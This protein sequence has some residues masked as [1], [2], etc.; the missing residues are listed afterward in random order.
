MLRSWFYVVLASAALA[1]VGVAQEPRPPAYAIASRIPGPDGGWD[2]ASVDPTAQRLYV[3]RTDGVM[4]VD[5]AS[6]VVTPHLVASAHGHAALAIPGTREVISTNGEANTAVIFDGQSGHIRATIPT[7]TKPDAVVFDPATATL[8]IMNPGSGDI[9]VV[10]PASAAVLATVPVGGSLELGAA[11]GQ[12]Q[13]FVNVEDRNEVAVIDTRTRKVIS[14]YPLRG[15]EGPTGI[16]Y[17]PDRRLII[18]ACANGL[19]VI[20]SPKGRLISSLPVG[21]RPDG[22][23]YDAARHLAFVPSGGDGTLAVIAMGS[24]PRVIARVQTAKGA[25]TAALDPRSGRIYLP[26]A[27]FAPA[28]GGARPQPIAG[29]FSVI[30]IAP[31]REAP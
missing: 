25:R 9:T 8:W 18:S 22:A 28:V 14:R 20:S 30:V 31:V 2:L 21:P 13:L 12:G 15:C 6:G 1:Q 7:G 11:S 23:L 29:T 26:S 4:A 19:A 16:A 3:A 10:D 27:Q 24:T 17:A 5:L